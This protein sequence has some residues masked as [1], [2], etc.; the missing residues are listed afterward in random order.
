[1]SS[2][3]AEIWLRSV[4]ETGAPGTVMGSVRYCSVVDVVLHLAH[5]C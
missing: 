4:C 5:L 2:T 3:V 1:M